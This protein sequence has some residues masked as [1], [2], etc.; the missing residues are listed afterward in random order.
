MDDDDKQQQLH[1]RRAAQRSNAFF[2][3]NEAL[4]SCIWLV[5][6]VLNSSIEFGDFPGQRGASSSSSNTILTMCVRSC[7]AVHVYQLH[8]NNS[9]PIYAKHVCT[10]Y[11]GCSRCCRSSRWSTF[12]RCSAPRFSLEVGSSTSCTPS[13]APSFSYTPC[14]FFSRSSS[15]WRV[16]YVKCVF[17]M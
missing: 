12:S 16:S 14:T 5:D 4:L 10:T 15:G 13:S 8:T 2:G 17:D 9:K 11:A 1:H 7:L 6:I 3:L